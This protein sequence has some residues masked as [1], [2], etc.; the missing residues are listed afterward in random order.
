MTK[1]LFSTESL[2]YSFSSLEEHIY[3]PIDVGL[4]NSLRLVLQWD[5]S[6]QYVSRGLIHD[7]LGGLAHLCSLFLTVRS[8]CI[9][10]LIVQDGDIYVEKVWTHP[11]AWNQAQRTEASL[12]KLNLAVLQTCE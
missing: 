5:V 1:I 3:Y 10:T 4:G 11:T 6:R 12:A 8:S 2:Y 9:V 7:L